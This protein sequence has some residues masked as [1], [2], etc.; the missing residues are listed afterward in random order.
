MSIRSLF[1]STN[2]YI[3]TTL[4]ETQQNWNC[5]KLYITHIYYMTKASGRYNA[6]SDWL[7]ARSEQGIT[8]L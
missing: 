5:L 3:G 7:R 4:L 2:L 8:Q 1:L 6:R